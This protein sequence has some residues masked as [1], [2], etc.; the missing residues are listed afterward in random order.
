MTKIINTKQLVLSELSIED[1]PFIL[2]LLNTK[3]WIKYIGDRNIKTNEDACNYILNGPMNS[4]NKNGFGLF[5]VQLKSDKTSIGICGLIKRESLEDIDIGFAF[6]P[7]FENKGFGFEA[8]AATI[9]YAKT[10]LHLNRVVAIT[11]MENLKS[12]KLLEKIGLTFEKNIQLPG[13][14]KEL[15]LFTITF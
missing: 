13:E 11:M 2:E 12:I 9:H 7:Q 14:Y 15:M 6:L 3:S 1:A 4:Y 5:L 10:V 8:A